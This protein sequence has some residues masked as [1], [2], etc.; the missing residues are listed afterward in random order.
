MLRDRTRSVARPSMGTSLP[1]WRRSRNYAPIRPP[2][3]ALAPSLV[4]HAAARATIPGRLQ[5]VAGV[6][7]SAAT[8]ALAEA[9][10]LRLIEP[11]AAPIDLA[12]DGADEVDP[13]GN[14]IK[15]GGG[16][17]TREKLVAL[18]ARELII[19]VDETKM[20]ERLGAAAKSLHAYAGRFGER[21][22][23]LVHELRR[24]AHEQLQRAHPV[25]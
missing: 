16:A 11:G 5:G 19:V 20:V 24:V 6:P 21:M 15:G 2:P 22:A 8:A 12:I 4:V 9:L 18:A 3:P 17:L 7:T 23:R 1:A 25:E 10:G 13:A 14:L